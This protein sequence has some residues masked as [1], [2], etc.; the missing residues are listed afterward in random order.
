MKK[1]KLNLF[2][3]VYAYNVIYAFM[4]PDN[5]HKG[6][7]KIGEA[8]LTTNTPVS[9][10][11]PNTKEL[12]QAA[13]KRI[14]EYTNTAG[15]QYR[16]LHTELA[17]KKISKMNLEE[18][19]AFRDHDVHRVLLNSGIKRTIIEGTTGREWFATTLSTV[20]SA[21]AAVKGG[22]ENLSHSTSTVFE[23]IELRPEQE[24]AAKQTLLHFKN[25]N[26][27]LW[28]A[29][30]R[31]GKTITALETIKRKG[32]KRTIIL[33]HRPVV[34]DGWYEDFNKVF[35]DQRNYAFGSKSNG[36]SI[37]SLLKCNINFVY[38]AS[39]QDLR[40]SL[41]IGGKFEKNEEIFETIWDFVIVD[42]AHEGTK[43]ALGNETVNAILK[44]SLKKTKFLAL[45][46][47]PFNLL[48]EYD[49]DSIFTWDYVMEQE[50]KYTW[51]KEH[52]GDSNPYADLPELCIYTYDLGKILSR[53][54]HYLALEDRAFNFQEFFRTNNDKLNDISADSFVH[55]ND[56]EDFL[57]LMTHKDDYN[58]YPFSNE[59]YR[60]LF[61]HTL[62][63]VP[64]IK[65]AKALKD[66]MMQHPVF[67]SGQ[68]DIVNVAGS[69]DE[70]SKD[71]LN[72]VKSAIKRAEENNTY[73]ITLSC[74]KLTTGVTVKE[75]TA[76]FMLAGS[77]SVSAAS[78]LQTIFRVQ[79]P[80]N[81]NGQIKQRA[82]V[83]DFAPDRTLKMV[84]EAVSI[85]AK[86][87][88]TR[89]SDRAIL[90]KFLNY[91]PV[92]ALSGSKMTEYSTDR[93]LQQLK[94]AYAERVVAHGFD[95]NNLYNDSLFELDNID[96]E[97][98]NSL[99][100]IIGNTK[101]SHKT[102]EIDI[103]DQG[104]NKEKY[105]KKEKLDER[106]QHISEEELQF[107]KIQEEK[108]KQRQNAISI[109]RGISIRM[110][111]LI[112]GSNISYDEDITLDKFLNEVDELSWHEFMPKG[113]TK[114]VFHQFRR[115]YDEDVFI[116]AGRKIRSLVKAA[117]DYGILE[118]IRILAQLFSYFKNPDKETV[119]TPWRTVNLHLSQ[120]IG[121]YSFFT[122]NSEDMLNEPIFINDPV[123]T[124]S[125]FAKK[126]TRILEIN[127][128][129]GLYL[130][131][132][133]YSLYK[134]NFANL[135]DVASTEKQKAIWNKIVE[136]NIFV[137]CNSPMAKQIVQRTLV[138]YASANI[139]AHFF[140]N[141]PNQMQHKTEKLVD[142]I[143]SCSFWGKEG[144]SAMKFDVIV[145]NPPFQETIGSGNNSSL[146][147]Q[148]FPYFVKT[149]VMLNP[150]YSSLIIPARWFTGRAQDG[151]FLSLRK[152]LK[153]NN[154]F[155]KIVYYPDYSELFDGVTIA[156]GVVYY[157]YDKD[158]KED[159]LFV[160]KK[161]QH[162]TE[163]MRPL[164]EDDLDVIISANDMISILN[165]VRFHKD[166]MSLTQ[167][168]SGRNAFGL[169]GKDSEVLAK[170]KEFYF[171]GALEV[172]CAHEKIRYIERL[173]IT[174][175]IDW[176]DCYKIFI[177]K[178]NGAAGLI[179]DEK[180]ASI[181][182]KAYIG[183]K[184]SICTDSLIP[185]GKFNTKNEAIALQK[186][187][188]TK[189]LRFMVGILK[190]SQN[191]SQ[192][193]YQF[194]PLQDFSNRSDI[195]WSVSIDKLD[196]QLY[197]KYKLC[198]EEI[199]FIE[200]KIK[201]MMI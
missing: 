88:K 76:V 44:P 176:I 121:G 122:E 49:P 84:T 92:I 78:Y 112:F 40:G 167:V 165:K 110:P 12:N 153:E 149:A 183:D 109:L 19:R 57:N 193:V 4:I 148:L 172:R 186:Y 113:V 26:T 171:E 131:Y 199:E 201:S 48:D 143:T 60:E 108:R 163:I 142:K 151:S 69:D 87:G 10:L 139:N 64:G 47:T 45:S 175:N 184:G 33:T 155:K 2:K 128:K 135:I 75:W 177:S 94:K 36:N 42:E 23:S 152:F 116:A 191:I 62:W 164:F 146:A 79:S 15:I 13:H 51:D 41:A 61:K 14:K 120:C 130:L 160:E 74:G 156:G 129:T 5:A 29:K 37:S 56:I 144:D 22:W 188:A 28:N 66:L 100:A 20:K 150:K 53:K 3:N 115:Y 68:F 99:K 39:I 54:A 140:E 157:L 192:N 134:Q 127:A 93:L 162:S 147:K 27:M 138:G 185:I 73:T 180:P 71:A 38:F 166:F 124:N 159:V 77:Y 43:T 50:A 133:V 17:I 181:I 194:A 102:R 200:A 123:V 35:G 34:N 95:D 9:Q 137:M 197:K 136:E 86:A 24:E 106:P 158:Y 46:G 85:S 196:E 126:D 89:R 114:E 189:F 80:C 25:S 82:Y 173:A 125:I 97:K 104:F 161:H 96:I 91:C 111:L 101:A 31:F 83:F 118:R 145:G 7:I 119:L 195:D 8:V 182:G 105:K 70:E 170:T 198:Q 190:T 65:A 1:E 178:G 141:L 98:L 103:N 59:E 169:T 81:K 32:F 117:D 90:A 63:M 11:E 67:G 168:T 21:I 72:S 16:L 174:K 179:N 52:F 154:H 132:M 58:A 6:L 107:R 187:L 18:L 55:R 30:M